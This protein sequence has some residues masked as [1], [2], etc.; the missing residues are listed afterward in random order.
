MDLS[1]L[2]GPPPLVV[3]VEQI[4]GATEYFGDSAVAL[5]F[6][7]AGSGLVTVVPVRPNFEGGRAIPTESSPDVEAEI[8]V[9]TSGRVFVPADGTSEE[10]FQEAFDAATEDQRELLDALAEGERN[11]V[12]ELV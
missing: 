12:E 1:A 8:I 5:M 3:G 6:R 2:L 10:S 9:S 7:N 11:A 4:K